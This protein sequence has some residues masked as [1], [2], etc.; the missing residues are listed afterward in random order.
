MS[1]SEEDSD[2][3]DEESDFSES[4]EDSDESGSDESES[5]ESESSGEA[6]RKKQEKAEAERKAREESMEAFK[7]EME[8]MTK[9]KMDELEKQMNDLREKDKETMQDE[10]QKALAS[11]TKKR[12][13]SMQDKLEDFANNI[14]SITKIPES[15]KVPPGGE[16]LQMEKIMDSMDDLEAKMDSLLEQTSEQLKEEKVPAVPEIDWKKEYDE[17]KEE[18]DKAIT[19]P[20]KDQFVEDF[21]LRTRLV[22]RNTKLEEEVKMLNGKVK[23]LQNI[24]SNFTPKQMYTQEEFQDRY[25]LDRRR[26]VRYAP[27]RKRQRSNGHRTLLDIGRRMKGIERRYGY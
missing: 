5:E 7:K 14:E 16:N 19:E 4:G 9:V 24:L 8:E 25:G 10:F 22:E 3:G 18:Y 21:M 11:I 2:V 26:P 6:D 23:Y 20:P 15:I 12:M 13:E 1:D 17:L 27:P